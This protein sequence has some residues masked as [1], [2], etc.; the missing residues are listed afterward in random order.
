MEPKSRLKRVR[1]TV[2]AVPDDE[3]VVKKN[4]PGYPLVHVILVFF[5]SG[6][7]VQGV[8]L[9]RYVVAH[10]FQSG[11]NAFGLGGM[12]LCPFLAMGLETLPPGHCFRFSFSRSFRRAIEVG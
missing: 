6:V 4:K 3:D 10:L 2:G 7:I 1:N 5:W 11:A 8:E 9:E 12:L